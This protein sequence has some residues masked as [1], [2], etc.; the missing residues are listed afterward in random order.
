MIFHRYNI[1]DIR[2]NKIDDLG[3]HWLVV[4]SLYTDPFKN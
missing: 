2:E 3:G 4:F 1:N